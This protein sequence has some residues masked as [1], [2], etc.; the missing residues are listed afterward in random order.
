MKINYI[1]TI[2]FR[3]NKETFETNLYDITSINNLCI[4]NELCY[5]KKKSRFGQFKKSDF[6]SD[7]FCNNI[8]DSILFI[9]LMFW[10]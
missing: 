1:K 2:G 9:R 6:T 7:T 4:N 10:I 8:F 5:K 3:K